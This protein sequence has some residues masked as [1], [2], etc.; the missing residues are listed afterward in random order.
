MDTRFIAKILPTKINGK[1]SIGTGYP[2][3][4]DLVLTARHVVVFAARDNMIP[5]SVEWPDFGYADTN[6]EIVFDGGEECDIA[7]L[8][9]RIPPQVNLP[10]LL[11]ARRFPVPHEE[12]ASFGYPRMG[13]DSNEEGVR[14][15]VSALGKFHPPD[16]ISHK[17]S[18]TSESDAIEKEGWCGISGAPVF[19]GG[20]IYG[21]ISSTPTN[22]NECFK[23]VL[24]PWLV[25]ND[26]LFKQCLGMDDEQ[27]ECQKFVEGQ[28]QLIRVMLEEIKQEVLFAELATKLNL[29]LENMTA[30]LLAEA[31][32]TAFDQDCL[33]L[34]D[35]LLQVAADS[36][37]QDASE[38][39]LET[40]RNLFY[41]F[42]SLMASDSLAARQ[43]YID[44]SVYSQMAT[45]LHLAPIFDTSP[46]FIT[47]E[48]GE[49][50]GRY[51]MDASTLAVKETGWEEEA[52]KQEAL[53]VVYTEVRKKAA[54][55]KVNDFERK[56]LST[57]IKQRQNKSLNQLH[58]FELN[59]ADEALHSNPLYMTSYCEALNAIDCLPD[60]PVVHYGEQVASNEAE[61]SAKLDELFEILIRYGY[62]Q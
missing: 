57:T 28:K 29:E 54:P 25:N 52:F 56:K 36:L 20:L 61:L 21:V 41:L 4:N 42:V 40:I 47:T 38:Q 11:L 5:I 2:V 44:L 60:L 37:K 24:I 35:L 8:R 16:V 15:K 18:L 43:A 49:L 45:E 53:K 32:F 62:G 39:K 22:R 1:R 13:K 9:C 46:D 10:A 50:K 6:A 7:V 14:D 17:I 30:E 3:G 48:A 19:Q 51:A 33:G 34:Y 58:R 55:E 59:R 31:L 23:A 26:L 27:S 12:W